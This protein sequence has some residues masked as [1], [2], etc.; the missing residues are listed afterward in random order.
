MRILFV[1]VEN[2]GLDFVLR[3][4]EAD[5]DVRWC[6]DDKKS[7]A[8]EG[9]KGF[10]II[11]DWRSSMPWA[12]DGLILT[13]GNCK[14]LREF[15]R[16]RDLGYKVFAPTQRSAS[17]EI[18]RS[19]GLEAM[20]QAGIDVPEYETFKSLEDAQKFARKS[21][22]CW[23]F[24]TLGD[25]DDKSL[26]FVSCNPAE[27]VGWL[28]RQIARGMKLKGPCMLQEKID[29]LA[30]FGVSGWFGPEGFL[31]GKW[32]ECWEH[33]KLMNGEIGPNTGEMG[34]V[35]QY[36][37][38]SKL[39]D[40]MLKP[41]ETYLLKAGHRGDFAMGAGVDKSG[42]VWPF[43]F[44]ARCG[45]PAFFI[46]TASH[47][48][49]P[50]QW[51]RD[52]LDG[53]DTLKVKPGVALGVVMAQPKFP[54]NVSRPDEV[55]GNPI[56]GLEELDD[57]AHLIGVMMAK[58]PKM[59]D[60]KVVYSPIPQ[61]TGEYVLCMTGL[62]KTVSKARDTVYKAVAEVKFPNAMYRTDIGEKLEPVLGKMHEFGY[63][64]ETE[65]V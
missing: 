45:W 17:L 39:A 28:D 23:V 30:E 33:K 25:E 60:D 64:M 35:C 65:F 8:G 46:Q 6:P 50:A 41:M 47:K 52:L 12:R 58:G 3:C 18:K 31:P 10:E 40:E 4:A 57:Q 21:D 29:M 13:S 14:Y 19:I 56:T 2:M 44:T 42:K 48:G 26:S 16:F 11:D 61:T 1:D 51:M 24:K 36:V 49:D 54:Y 9:F 59:Y 7:R 20:T 32:Q 27:M 63:A 55:E 15:D 37:E 22:R 62:G 5:H 43:E 38:S 34:T 53:E